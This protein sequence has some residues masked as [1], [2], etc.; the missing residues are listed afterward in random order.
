M[1]VH[2]ACFPITDCEQRQNVTRGRLQHLILPSSE[3][4][5]FEIFVIKSRSETELQTNKFALEFNTK[6]AWYFNIWSL[7]EGTA[8]SRFNVNITIEQNLMIDTEYT[9]WKRVKLK[10][11]DLQTWT[12]V[13]TCVSA[14]LWCEVSHDYHMENSFCALK[15]EKSKIRI[16]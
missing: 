6:P 11:R 16:S 14:E 12:W 2:P 9:D 4:V 10:P 13:R 15:S 7:D 1:V 8:V 3:R 5:L